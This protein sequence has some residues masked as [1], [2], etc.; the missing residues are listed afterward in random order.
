MKDFVDDLEQVICAPF[1]VFSHH[2]LENAIYF[3]DNA[4]SEDFHEFNVSRL[5]DGPN[6]FDRKCIKFGMTYFKILEKNLN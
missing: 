6:N 2:I 1:L 3:L 4:H 5:D